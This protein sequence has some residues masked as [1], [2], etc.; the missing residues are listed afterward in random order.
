[1]RNRTVWLIVGGAVAFVVVGIGLIVY[2]SRGLF[3]DAMH[4]FQEG[5]AFGR[6]KEATECVDEAVER[7]DPQRDILRQT[8]DSAFIVACLGSSHGSDELCG[9]V[10]QTSLFEQGP[11]STWA[12]TQ[13]RD[14][15]LEGRG[16]PLIFIQVASYCRT[17]R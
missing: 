10:P 17:K 4:G 15:N 14:R 9:T 1:M 8:T 2:S 11:I 3:N 6:G 16:C 7:Y 5:S 13:C 12:E